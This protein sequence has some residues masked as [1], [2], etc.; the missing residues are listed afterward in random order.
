MLQVDVGARE[1]AVHRFAAFHRAASPHHYD[2]SGRYIGGGLDAPSAAALL[3]VT[4]S[5]RAR[6]HASAAASRALGRTRDA[7]A[8]AAGLQGE[9]WGSLGALAGAAAGAAVSSGALGTVAPVAAAAVPAAA[10][11][12]TTAADGGSGS[13]SGSEQG[14]LDCKGLSA[15][16]ASGA[17]AAASVSYVPPPLNPPCTPP[18]S[19]TTRPRSA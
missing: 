5:A 12:T 2:A 17:V 13:G 15:W 16:L 8:L 1:R 10:A 3:E 18:Q 6:A 9:R 14:L 4:E 7:E 11:P 19:C